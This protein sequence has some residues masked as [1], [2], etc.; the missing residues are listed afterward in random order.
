MAIGG[1]PSKTRHLAGSDRRSQT[2]KGVL[3]LCVLSILGDRP[4]YGYGL[5]T[6]LGDG[7]LDLVAEGSIYPLLARLEKRNL[8]HSYFAPSPDGPDRKYYELTPDGRKALRAGA[9]EWRL[10]VAEVSTLL[11]DV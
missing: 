2:L 7:G 4:M 9:A 6:A 11:D 8:V 5:V 1:A 3:D 10:V